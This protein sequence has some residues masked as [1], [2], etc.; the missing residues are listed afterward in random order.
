MWKPELS[1]GMPL[2]RAI[3]LALND[4]ITNGRLSSGER[5]PTHREL[6]FQL[7][8]T[9]GTVTKAFTEAER[10]GLLV[11]RVGRGTYVLEFPEN[12]VAKSS[13]PQ[14]FIDLS[15]NTVTI[16]PF[17]NALNR[18]FGALSRRKS[19]HGLLEYH[20]VPGLH[21]HRVAGAK[22]MQLRGMSVDP[23]RV[24]VCNGAQEG[25]MASLAAVTNPGGV[26][27]T[28][29]LGYAGIKRFA[30]S[31]RLDVRGVACDK[32]GIVPE[33]LIEAAKNT[34]VSAILCSP[35]LHNP[36]NATMPLERRE[37]ILRIAAKLDAVVIENDS[38]GHISGSTLPTLTALD[39]ERCI[40]ICST[41]KSIAPGL[42]IGFLT[43][44]ASLMPKLISGVH[45][46]SWTSPSVMGEITAILVENGMADQFLTWHRKEA[47][48]RVAMAQQILKQD[49]IGSTTPTYHVWLPLPAPW[50]AGE[51]AAEVRS[52][53][54]IISPAD[55]FAVDRSSAPHAVRIS[56]GC[57]GSRTRL[58]EGLK[59][60]AT[61]LEARPTFMRSAV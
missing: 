23:Q 3:L 30:D 29:S 2:Y 12:I 59:T 13:E 27:L 40:Y 47:A 15:T 56:L 28:E 37:A 39:P 32:H 58:T 17:N 19:L 18:V 46:T 16:E 36:T 24:I 6:A 57:V 41:S 20:P 21:R 4:D 34:T 49:D 42:R 25:L 11:S 5:L 9:I 31:F 7:G 44:P 38:Y 35:T 14:E 26:V 54:T 10:S 45:A 8:V 1:S 55:H 60:I 53:G 43:A 22:W 51:F 50:R 48:E 52:R 61:A 33:K